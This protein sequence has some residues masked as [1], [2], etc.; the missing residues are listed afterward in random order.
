MESVVV[1]ATFVSEAGKRDDLLE[2]LKV[3]IPEVHEED[4]CELYAL[5]EADNGNIVLI[6][7]WA[8][9]ESLQAHAEGDPVRRLNA[10]IEPLLKEAPVVVAMSAAPVGGSAGA[11]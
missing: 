6:E 9:R 2:A 7:K 1:T 8:S 10:A 3:A 11:L 4:G 5:H